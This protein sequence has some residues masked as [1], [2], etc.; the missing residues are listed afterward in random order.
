MLSHV[1]KVSRNGQVSIPATARARWRTERAVVV[2]LGDRLVIRPLPSDPVDELIGK[3]AN[4]RSDLELR[5]CVRSGGGCPPRSPQD[6]LTVLDSFAAIALLRGEPAARKV[7]CDQFV[8]CASSECRMRKPR[9]MSLNSDSST[10]SPSMLISLSVP[11]CC[12]HANTTEPAQRG[13]PGRL[14]RRGSLP[15]PR[16]RARHG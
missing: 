15:Q 13:E 7:P 11:D 8:E 1:M 4:P 9:W 2:D 10:R 6:S 14:R 16:D 3:Y 5:P 12:G